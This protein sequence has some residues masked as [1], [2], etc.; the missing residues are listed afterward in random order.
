[1]SVSPAH[2]PVAHACLVPTEARGRYW[3]PQDQNYRW[4]Q[5]AMWVLGI[6]PRPLWK[7]S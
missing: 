3:I 7:N 2:M 1:M 6:E 5:T 4:L